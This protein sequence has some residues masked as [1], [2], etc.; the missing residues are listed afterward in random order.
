D[1]ASLRQAC[2]DERGRQ[3]C[4]CGAN[5]RATTTL[6]H[7]SSPP[8]E[9]RTMYSPGARAAVPVMTREYDPG[10]NLPSDSSVTNRPPMSDKRTRAS[11]ELAR[12][13]ER[14]SA[15]CAGL[16]WAPGTA[17]ATGTALGRTPAAA[18]RRAGPEEADHGTGTALA[19]DNSH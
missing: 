1:L 7:A 17:N 4:G 10:P 8:C 2:G 12:S 9:S 19:S 14:R 13:T 3:S 5:Y 15:P 11:A 6:F 18:S 16:G